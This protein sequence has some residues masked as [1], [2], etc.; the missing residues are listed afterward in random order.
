MV[1]HV[2]LGKQTTRERILDAAG[3]L[4]ALK[5]F[6]ATTIR[7]ICDKAEANIAAVN[8]HFRDKES[9][10]N[11]LVDL[12]EREIQETFIDV[13]HDHPEQPIEERL[14]DFIFHFLH[15]RLD[16]ERAAWKSIF[17]HNEIMRPSSRA[18]EMLAELIRK[19][20]KLLMVLVDELVDV[21]FS[22][23]A[24]LLIGQS[25]FGQGFFFFHVYGGLLDRFIEKLGHKVPLNIPR[26][27]LTLERIEFFARHI[28]DFSLAA[29]RELKM[30]HRTGD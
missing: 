26:D 30:H 19:E 23:E 1:D 12:M 2:E 22:T 5:G 14:Y 8:Y 15:R 16:P 9:L 6:S 3:E 13:V 25:I 27:E 24:K 7:D 18:V 17:F 21:S 20:Q 11:E 28:T 29:V 4:F 10:Y